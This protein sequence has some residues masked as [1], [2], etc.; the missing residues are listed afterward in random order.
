M[1]RRFCYNEILNKLELISC[2]DNLFW[3][4]VIVLVTTFKNHTTIIEMIDWVA[5]W[6]KAL[7]IEFSWCRLCGV[8]V[9]CESF[10]WTKV[11]QGQ[12]QLG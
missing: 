11:D 3:L 8:D 2:I 9:D 5:N 6:L 7:L 10:S 12:T 1:P 4:H